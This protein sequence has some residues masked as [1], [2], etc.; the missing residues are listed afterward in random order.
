MIAVQHTAAAAVPQA[1]KPACINRI[2]RQ[3]MFLLVNLPVGELT[4]PEAASARVIQP[5]TR[6][7]TAIHVELPKKERK[8]GSAKQTDDDICFVNKSCTHRTQFHRHE[9]HG[10]RSAAAMPCHAI[11][12]GGGRP[13][14]THLLLL[15]Q[16]KSRR[17]IRARAPPGTF[18]FPKTSTLP[19]T[20][21]PSAKRHE[22]SPASFTLHV[23]GLP[24]G[25]WFVLCR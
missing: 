1:H 3:G 20:A 4:I 21:L 14:F 18:C 2:S 16:S 8:K 13:C 24:S 23:C 10:F 19:S 9:M 12:Q 25:I 6:S 15:A 11:L 17:S 22:T 7:A 5:G